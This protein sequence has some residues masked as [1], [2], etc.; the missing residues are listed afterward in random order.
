VLFFNERLHRREGLG[1]A[2]VVLSLLLLVL[3]ARG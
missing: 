3:G 1:I 2:L